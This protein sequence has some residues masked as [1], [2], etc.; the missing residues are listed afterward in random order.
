MVSTQ[1]IVIFRYICDVMAFDVST[2]DGEKWRVAV[3]K[4]ASTEFYSNI[5]DWLSYTTFAIK[6]S[7][8]LLNVGLALILARKWLTRREHLA[9]NNDTNNNNNNGNNF[10]KSNA[11][12]KIIC[13]QCTISMIADIAGF[14]VSVLIPGWNDND[15]CFPYDQQLKSTSS[16]IKIFN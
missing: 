13:L 12:S 10:D 6:I 2:K 7:T 3:A 11:V 1:N 8:Y 16:T 5:N 9:N 14:I 4:F 15:P